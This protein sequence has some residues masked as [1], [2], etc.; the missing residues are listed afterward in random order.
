M[1]HATSPQGRLLG[2]FR[3]VREIGRGGMGVVYEAVDE[4]SGRRVALKVLEAHLTLQ[5]SAVDRFLR[6]AHAAAA[7]RHDHIV[8]V[9]RAGE[10]D[11]VHFFA[12]EL[13]DGASI[14]EVIVELAAAARGEPAR[15]EAIAALAT[16]YRE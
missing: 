16:P 4:T 1:P 12:M 8:P 3:I 5:R 13:V 7:L 15:D 11:G 14:A 2:D 10:Q 6:E 9:D